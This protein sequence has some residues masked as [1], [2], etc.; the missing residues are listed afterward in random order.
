VIEVVNVVVE[1]RLRDGAEVAADAISRED[2]R[3]NTL[4]EC[5]A[6]GESGAMMSEYT[7]VCT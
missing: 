2:W 1:A 7:G 5:P 3:V 6:G 4:V